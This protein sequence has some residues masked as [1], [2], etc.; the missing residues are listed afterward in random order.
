MAT[1][2]SV[3]FGEIIT[4]NAIQRAIP[5]PAGVYE[6]GTPTVGTGGSGPWTATLNVGGDLNRIAWREVGSASQGRAPI[7]EDA[8]IVLT[9]GIAAA[10]ATNPR[11]DLIVGCHQW[12]DGALING[13]WSGGT[14]GVG[15]PNGAMDASM[16][17]YYKVVTGTANAAA[18][19][20][21]GASVQGALGVPTLAPTYT[22]GSTGGPPVILAWVYVPKAGLGAPTIGAWAGTDMRWST[23]FAKLYG[24][25]AVPSAGLTWTDSVTGHVWTMTIANG[26]L[27][28]T[29]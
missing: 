6:M 13:C 5:L 7:Q 10:D 23:L 11:I 20:C 27:T 17:P 21:T 26:V 25:P 18:V 29:Y 14:A 3:L 15:N 2:I 24:P 12:V 8:A 16:Y 28:Q 9:N 4:D 1:K 22:S 19:P